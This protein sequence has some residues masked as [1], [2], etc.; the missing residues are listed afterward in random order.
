MS[1]YYKIVDIKSLFR[2]SG[3]L[4][5][6]EEDKDLIFDFNFLYKRYDR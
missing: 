5:F 4:F 6:V 3:S 2:D 1:D